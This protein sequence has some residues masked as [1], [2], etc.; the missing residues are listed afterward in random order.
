MRNLIGKIIFILYI[1]AIGV[2][3]FGKFSNTPELPADFL[4]IPIDK[5]MHFFMFLPFC[6]FLYWAFDWKVQRGWRKGAL[7]VGLFLIG[8]GIAY[9]TEFIQELIPHRDRDPQYF[10]ADS[11]GLAFGAILVLFFEISREK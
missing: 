6:V 5:W 2:L 7:A 3:C 9:S 11:I 4:G 1:I 10:I 8:A